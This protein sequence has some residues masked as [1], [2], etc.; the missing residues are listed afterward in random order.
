MQVELGLQLIL[1]LSLRSI[2]GWAAPEV[3]KPY[4]RAR[5][6]L[7]A[8]GERAGAVS[9]AVGTD[10]FPRHSRRPAGLRD[11]S[12]SS[13]WRRRTRPPTPANLVAAHQMMASVNEFLG[14][15]VRSNEH[16][17]K[18]VA[19]HDPDQH[20]SFISRFGLDPGMIVARAVGAAGVVPR[21]SRQS[22]SRIQATVTLARSLKHPISIVFAVALAENIHLL[23]GEAAEAVFLGDEMIAICREYGLAQEVEWGR[24]FQALAFADL[25]RRGR[26]RRAAA[27]QPG[28][29]GADARRAAA[30]DVPRAP[31][32]RR[33]SRPI[34]RRR[35]PRRPGR[36]RGLRARSQRSSLTAGSAP[37]AGLRR[38]EG[39]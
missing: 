16:A 24:C 25:G 2:Q 20:L 34:A 9:R 19:L 32:R 5:A 30:A 18:A 21:V 6:D 35:A 26:G 29:A 14:H 13:S 7:P 23:R 38:P 36:L 1:G 12:P 37:S 4:L 10:A 17:D 31:R 11:R 27:R 39:R 33:C 22:L 3:E 15:T 28:G 8:A